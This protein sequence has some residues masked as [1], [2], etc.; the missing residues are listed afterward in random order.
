MKNVTFTKRLKQIVDNKRIAVVGMGN[1]DRAD[2]GFGIKVAESLKLE[3]PDRIFIEDE[4]ME[5][6]LNTINERKDIDFVVFVD[7]VDANEKNGTLLII[8][9][10]NIEDIKYSH[11]I[12]LKLYLSLVDKPSCIIGIQPE[13]LNFMQP[14]SEEVVDGIRKTIKMLKSVMKD[15]VGS[16]EKD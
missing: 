16:E 3:F 10:E 9:K 14:V 6:I 1:V 11:K 2:D 12:P 5:G 8:E 7:T 4:G 15:N 13:Q